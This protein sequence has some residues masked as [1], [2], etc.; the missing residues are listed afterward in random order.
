MD[1]RPLD[2]VCDSGSG[3]APMVTFETRHA[4]KIVGSPLHSTVKDIQSRLRILVVDGTTW[5]PI[6]NRLVSDYHYLGH[7]RMLGQRL[8]HLALVD[9]T[10]VAALGWRAGSRALAPR[11]YYIGWSMEQRY[12]RLH[13]IVNNN[14]FLIAPWVFVRHLGSHILARIVKQLPDDWQLKYHTQLLLLETFVDPQRFSGTV[15]RAS[16]WIHVGSTKGYTKQG[17]GYRFHGHPKDVYVY[18]LRPDFRQII[19]CLEPSRPIPERHSPWPAVKET[20]MIHKH[21]W[22][23]GILEDCGVT[24]DRVAELTDRLTEFHASFSRVFNRSNQQL[25]GCVYLRGL[26]S[27]LGVNSKSH[28]SEELC[29]NLLGCSCF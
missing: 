9:D 13:Q 21:D 14:R 4:H 24:A 16:N 27:Q 25:Y 7:R 22:H 29:E 2:G 23:P 28:R 26:L 5:E 10:P 17:R 19:G 20:M 12:D 18:P 1:T 3:T 8:K 15:Y 6:W 11:D